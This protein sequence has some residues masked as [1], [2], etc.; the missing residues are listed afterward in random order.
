MGA[1]RFSLK[2]KDNNNPQI[3]A[4]LAGLTFLVIFDQFIVMA[5]G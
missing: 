2:I 5:Y 1:E 3:V 4:N